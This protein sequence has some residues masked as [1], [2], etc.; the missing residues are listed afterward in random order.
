MKDVLKIICTFPGVGKL[1]GAIILA[2][3]GDV[4]RFKNLASIFSEKLF[5]KTRKWHYISFLI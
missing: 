2:G 4:T 5:G 1:S 3:L